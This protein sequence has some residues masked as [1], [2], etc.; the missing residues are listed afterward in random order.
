MM[1][2]RELPQV[3]RLRSV[4][5]DAGIGSSAALEAYLAVIYGRDRELFHHARRVAWISVFIASSIGVRE[6]FT[7]DIERAALLHEIGTRA[8]GGPRAGTP[9]ARSGD[10]G[11]A[12]LAAHDILIATPYLA[13]AAAI[14]LGVRER[15]DG[16]GCPFGLCAR[17]IPLGARIAAIADAFDTLVFEP[18][19]RDAAS[20]DS[21]NAQLVGE[22]G[23]AFDPMLV[24][25]WL[26]ALDRL[27]TEAA[28]RGNAGGRT[29][30]VAVGLDGVTKRRIQCS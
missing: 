1:V 27:G 15:Y 16:S 25:A 2:G 23:S 10:L 26:R 7:G 22:A 21:A 29:K 14:V 24:R 3:V 8:T 12:H 4:F 17:E 13:P 20:V 11:R 6:P 18:H 19:A 5:A 28:D 9:S 30:Q